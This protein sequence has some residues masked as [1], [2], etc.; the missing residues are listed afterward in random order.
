MEYVLC[1]GSGVLWWRAAAVVVGKTPARTLTCIQVLARE[2][3]VVLES[4][5]PAG[6]PSEARLLEARFRALFTMLPRQVSSWP[7]APR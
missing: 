1:S 7:A 6:K 2:H 3:G 4:T 5:E